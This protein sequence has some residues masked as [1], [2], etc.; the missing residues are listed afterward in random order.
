M[1]T[2]AEQRVL[3]AWLQTSGHLGRKCPSC[4]VIAWKARVGALMQHLSVKHC[5]EFA[6]EYDFFSTPVRAGRRPGPLRALPKDR[7]MSYRAAGP[8]NPTGQ[9]QAGSSSGR[10]GTPR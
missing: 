1:L 10:P 6:Q 7:A 5:A 2:P 4:G 9:H 8:S 3:D